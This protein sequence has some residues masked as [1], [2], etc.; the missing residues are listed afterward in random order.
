MA[1]Q[2]YQFLMIFLYYPFSSISFLI[3]QP[4]AINDRMSVDRKIF[5]DGDGGG[6]PGMG[7]MP[8]FASVSVRSGICQSWH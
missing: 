1:S 4:L 5:H 8:C 6:Y 3:A 2:K 7:L